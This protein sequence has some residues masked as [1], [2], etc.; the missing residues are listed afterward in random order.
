[1]YL[2]VLL[3][4]ALIAC[5]CVVSFGSAVA[6]ANISE[7]EPV[8]VVEGIAY[9]TWKEYFESD[10]VASGRKCGTM[11]KEM[12]DIL[13]P[14]PGGQP[15]RNGVGAASGADC[16][17]TST[18]PNSNYENGFRWVIPVV[19]H[20]LMNDACGQGAMTDAN[21]QGQIDI[22]NEDFIAIMGSNGEDGNNSEIYFELATTDPG[23]APTT[24][25][26]RNC[27][28][29]WF[30]DG[31]NYFNTLAWDPNRY[32]NIY[33]NQASGA[34]GYVPFLPADAG[35]TLVGGNS[36]R[37]VILHSTFGPD[38]PPSPFDLGRTGT[39][40][41]GHYLGLEHTFSGGCGT[42]TMPGC[43]SSGDMIC[44]TNSESGPFFGNA[45]AGGSVSC[46]TQDP[47]DNYMDYSDDICMRQFTVEQG[48]RM[49]C[50]LQHWRPNLGS[51]V[52]ISGG[53]DI[54]ADGFE[55]GNTSAW[56]QL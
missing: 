27:N 12:R 55:S 13:F 6:A 14:D 50:S 2:R 20:V 56:D 36:D 26:T 29:S 48:R 10:L 46:G 16:S 53:D 38:A 17:S 8:I 35:G 51:M 23:G 9:S 1:M 54:F 39:H 3:C 42:G 47:I 30:N 19:V 15:F 37:V 7:A 25:I 33:S 34:L 21:V 43:Y 40:E 5:V 44:D 41:V 22:L 31:G 24:G 18:D 32:L 4:R 52:P 11:S 45:C 28:T 49:R